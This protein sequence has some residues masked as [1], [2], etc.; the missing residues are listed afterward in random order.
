MSTSSRPR[1]AI[2][3]PAIIRGGRLRVICGM[4]GCLNRM[5]IT[6]E[7]VTSAAADG[8]EEQLVA[9]PQP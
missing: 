9:G 6:P 3:Q 2:C 1:V 8:V 4:V 5:G 7:I